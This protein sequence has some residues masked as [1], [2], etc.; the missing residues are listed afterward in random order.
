MTTFD[1]SIAENYSHVFTNSPQM[2]E[3]HTLRFSEPVH[4]TQDTVKVKNTQESLKQRPV[5]QRQL[6][7][8]EPVHYS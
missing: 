2:I 4:Y 7:F 5:K 8:S 3:Q 1:P 6:S